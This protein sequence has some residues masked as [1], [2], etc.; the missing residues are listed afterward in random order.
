M[1]GPVIIIVLLVLFPVAVIMTGAV[2][3]AIVGFFV[4]KDRDDAYEGTEYL[5]LANGPAV[6]T[7]E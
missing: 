2:G 6:P 3:A 5:A 7:E 1:A 4:K